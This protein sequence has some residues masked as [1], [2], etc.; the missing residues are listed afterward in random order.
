[1][2]TVMRRHNVVRPKKIRNGQGEKTIWLPIGTITEFDNGGRI[3]EMN[4]RTE[5]YQVFEQKDKESI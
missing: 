1:M 3:L 4:D 2:A 5:V